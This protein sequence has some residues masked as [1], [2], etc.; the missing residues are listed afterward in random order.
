[1]VGAC[2]PDQIMKL[3]D[4]SPNAN[5][6]RTI[7]PAKIAMLKKSLI[8]FGDL[9]G[10]VFNRKSKH[11]VGGHQRRETFDPETDITITKKYSKP[12]KTG[13][14]AEGY[15]EHK[16]EKYNYREVFWDEMTE[17]AANIAANKG[18]G[19]WDIPQLNE[20]LK[21]LSDFDLDFDM[22]LT[23]FD[24]EDLE[25]LPNPIEVSAYTR[26][27]SQGKEDEDEKEKAPP[28]CKPGQVYALGTTRLKCGE[29]D[30][31]F[32]DFIIARWERQSGQDVVL[33][34]PTKKRAA[35]QLD[36]HV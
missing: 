16:G 1:M 15:F 3:K 5:N 18:A 9:S 17:K 27:Q 29:D 19:E 11:L 6:P 4:L 22:S 31:H 34:N 36:K 2:K 12:S 10:I 13:T 7:T 30:L 26:K 23:M 33:Q 21:D 20:W 35:K 32:C 28:R 25:A 14:V 24:A 8:K